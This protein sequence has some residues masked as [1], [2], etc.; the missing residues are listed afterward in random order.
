MVISAVS[1]LVVAVPKSPVAAAA[2]V[3]D[4]TTVGGIRWGYSGNGG[5]PR[6]PQLNY[7]FSIARSAQGDTYFADVESHVVRK[8]SAPGVTST[9]AGDG[10]G[11][12]SFGDSWAPP[13]YSGDGGPATEAKLR[14]PFGVAL[15]SQGNLYIADNGNNAIRRVDAGT[16]VIATIA[17]TGTYGYTGN[18][19]PATEATLGSPVSVAIDGNDNVYFSEF[20][21]H[22]V[23]KV[24][25]A[26]GV[27]S[28]VAGSGVSG[29]AG[30][31]GPATA[32][33]LASPEGIA[34][35]GAGNLHIA[36]YY[37]S[38]I[39]RVDAL[40]GVIT[41]VAG[42]PQS[43]GLAAGDG[44]P[45]TEAV[46]FGPFWVAFDEADQ[47]Y[48]SS[49]RANTV[50]R[51]DSAG[52]ITTI[53]GTGGR[54]YSGDGGPAT[55]ATL[56][57]PLGILVDGE[58][59]YIA[60]SYNDVIRRVGLASGTITTSAG[61]TGW[62]AEGLTARLAAFNY[63]HSV[64]VDAAGNAY[65]A[66][67]YD[68]TVRR[69][70]AA[71]GIVTTVA[72]NGITDGRTRAGTFSGDG[73]PATEAGLHFPT[74]LALDDQGHLYI[75]DRAN[76][77]IR[78][79]DLATGV[80]T[81]VAGTGDRGYAG[82]GG[83]ATDAM[84]DDVEG[85]AVDGDGALFIADNG[86]NRVRMVDP[87]GIITT[88]AGTG[89]WGYSGDDGA[90]TAAT[91]RGP[92]GVAVDPGGNV[93]IA[94]SASNVVRGVRRSD[95]IIDTIAGTGTAGYGGD[96]GTATAA[97]LSRP[98][99][100]AFDDGG[101]LYITEASNSTV[102]EVDAATGLIATVAG[103]GTAGYTGDDGPAAEAQLNEPLGVGVDPGGNLFVVDS[104][105]NAVRYVL[106]N[107]WI[108]VAPSTLFGFRRSSGYVADPVNTATGNFTTAHVDLDF[109][110]DG[111]DW[112]RTYNSR[113]P[114]AGALGPGW[115]AGF[116]ATALELPTGDVAVTDWDGRRVSFVRDGS[117][118]VRPEE[119]FADLTKNP[120]GTLALHHDDGRE[121]HFDQAG[122]LVWRRHWDGQG[123][124]LAYSDGRLAT[125]SHNAGVSLTFIYTGLR[126]TG[127]VASDGRQVS[128]GYTDGNLTS[129][130]DAAGGVTTYGYDAGDRLDRITDAD[131]VVVVE[132]T[133]DA[134]GRV[135][136]QTTPSGDALTF[137]YDDATGIT[138][139]AYA[140]TGSVSRYAHDH[141]GRLTS[142]TDAHGQTLTK[143]YDSAGNL[144]ALTDRR[145][146]ALT[147]TFDDRGNVLTRSSPEGVSESF[148][149]DASNRLSSGTAGQSSTTTFTYEGAQR[150]PS[151]V[152]DAGGQATAYTVD[153]DGLVTSA[154]DADGV[155][156][157]SATTT[158]AA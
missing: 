57:N 133:Y 91:L 117:T 148:T 105:N 158:G 62:S 95:G 2:E 104:A 121:E 116:D 24:D 59:L 80:I 49:H 67:T 115:S 147:Q 84:L 45:A 125:A 134:L 89:A 124:T 113:N 30:D 69:I 74:A 70:S 34:F 38:V 37:N 112:S 56:K 21:N 39:R 83:P 118:Y 135:V 139:V 28:V 88:F 43:T 152:V 36:D 123:V 48:I 47:L 102:R 136:G 41:T 119:F 1:G 73:G 19:G 5:G 75:A 26:T 31:G 46:L 90:A 4:I 78:R 61:H 128:F 33:E 122:R 25:T 72:G 126:L 142:I 13:G 98:A 106:R 132:S 145:G 150:I 20:N 64:V 22:V 149:Y 3:G 137:T 66:D 50:R 107:A 52:I 153:A 140:A 60:D 11:Y 58:W 18:G 63:P 35:D 12:D 77:R 156:A 109:T 130:T 16:G 6:A 85:L 53:A 10:A 97:Q 27:I 99:A 114:D 32:A 138:T 68:N 51:V 146:A 29:F 76:Y 143:S 131:G 141:Q 15:D 120:D 94:D 154:T 42:T 127:L 92:A 111:L 96:G 7:P 9:V 44:G 23:R 157:T 103:N 151:T 93:A 108:R 71:T 65:V 82:D 144:I 101:N 129:V 14:D 8:I 79:V 100:V 87:T 54:G 110:V 17:G 40:T 55:Q 86:N 81:T 155:V